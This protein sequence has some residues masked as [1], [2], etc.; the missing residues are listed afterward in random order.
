MYFFVLLSFLALAAFGFFLR[1]RARSLGQSLMVAGC[2]GCVALAAWQLYRSFYDS[3][4]ISRDRYHAVVAY[5]M[6]HQVAREFAGRKGKVCLIFPPESASS[7]DALDTLFETFARVLRPFPGLEVKEATLRV[8]AK[9]ARNGQVPAAAFEQAFA[10]VP[11]AVAYISFA[12][13]P[14]DSET[15]SVF[16]KREPPAVFIYDATGGTNW[17]NALKQR[18]IRA[19]IVPRPDVKP[20]GKGAIA[21]PPEAIFKEYF[22]MVTYESLAQ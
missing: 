16:S 10:E 15:L 17:G 22:L 3:G 19:V 13:I 20:P 14:Q 21:G 9:L 12:G 4:E 11:N 7:A 6:G 2:V 18:R 5:A 1:D 8:K